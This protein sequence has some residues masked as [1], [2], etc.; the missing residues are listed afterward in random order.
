[1]KNILESSANVLEK[2][3]R[4]VSQVLFRISCVLLIIMPLPVVIEIVNRRTIK[5][6]IPGIIEIEEYLLLFM[7][8]FALAIVQFEGGH[9]RIDLLYLKFPKWVQNVLGSA[10]SLLTLILFSLMCSELIRMGIDNFQSQEVSWG[11]RLPIW[12]FKFIAA[13]GLFMM[14][15]ATLRKFLLFLKDSLDDRRFFW[16]IIALFIACFLFA[17][18]VAGWISTDISPSTTGL[19]V[20]GLLFVLIFLGMPIGFAM[21]F[22]GFLGMIVVY[23]GTLPA[24]S[25]LGMSA[26][27][28]AANYQFTVLPLFLF[29]GQLAYRTGISKSVFQTAAT[30]MGRLPGGLSIATIGGCAGFSAIAG[31]S[32]STAVT[33]GSIAAPEMRQRKYDMRLGAACMAAGGTLGI[34]IPPSIGFIVYAIVTE[35]SIGKLFI[36]GII[37]GI[38]L[39]ALFMGVLYIKS[40]DKP[41]IN[42][43]GGPNDP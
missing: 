7:T 31:D 23:Q 37:P 17:A 28:N 20:M 24:L 21:G 10:T 42:A 40:Q 29:I 34:L 32:L 15:G 18:P 41:R 8:F 2:L 25:N 14:C 19:V 4:P 43:T 3:F 11:L 5:G 30:W 36:A 39:T 38:I 6:S 35:T 26:Y 12:I 13:F 1:M 33:M 16:L 22:M 9:W 27:S